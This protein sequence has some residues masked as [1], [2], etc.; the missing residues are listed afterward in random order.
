METTE[1]T[2]LC[3][4]CCAGDFCQH[5]G[6]RSIIK[7]SHTCIKCEGR[8]HGFPCSGGKTDE[9]TGMMCKQCDADMAWTKDTEEI[10]KEGDNEWQIS[11]RDKMKNQS[12]QKKKINKKRGI[13][14]TSIMRQESKYDGRGTEIGS[15]RGR[16]RRRRRGTSQRQVRTNAKPPEHKTNTTDPKR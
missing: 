11:Q 14:P 12:Q 8:F 15:R 6:G 3:V 5:P 4:L 7:L 13:G 16:G 9:M 2:T 10:G 1:S